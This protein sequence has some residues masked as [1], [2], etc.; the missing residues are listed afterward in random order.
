[1]NLLEPTNHPLLGCALIY[2]LIYGLIGEP[3]DGPSVAELLDRVRLQTRRHPSQAMTQRAPTQRGIS[4]KLVSQNTP[5]PVAF[6]TISRRSSHPGRKPWQQGTGLPHE[7]HVM[8]P[9]A[10]IREQIL[11]AE[12]LRQAQ[13]ASV[14]NPKAEIF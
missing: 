11:K 1:M 14:Q 2:E 13:L 8:N 4:Q 9:L 12:R 7:R 5:E 6:A 10:L 3:V